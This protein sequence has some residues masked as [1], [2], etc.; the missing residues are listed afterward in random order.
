MKNLLHREIKICTL[1]I[2]VEIV[3]DMY[4]H[5]IQTSKNQIVMYRYTAI[6]LQTST[7]VYLALSRA[8]M[9]ID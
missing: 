2:N 8:V 3:L 1:C 4:A 5:K 9:F 6:L 7:L